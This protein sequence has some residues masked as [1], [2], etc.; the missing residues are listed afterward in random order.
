MQILLINPPEERSLQYHVPPLGLLW[1]SS[2]LEADGFETSVIDGDHMGYDFKKLLVRV[3]EEEAQIVGI[4]A[5]SHSR[6][7][8]MQTARLIKHEL[9]ATTIVVGGPHFSLTAEDTLRHVSEIDVVVRGEGEYTMLDLVH[10]LQRKLDM[11]KVLGISFR[12]QGNIVHNPPR[13]FIKDLDSLPFPNRKKLPL[14]EYDMKLPVLG[15]PAITMMATRGCPMRCAFCASPAI[16]GRSYRVRSAGNVCD[17]IEYILGEYKREGINFYDDTVNTSK[18]RI[19]ELCGEIK[20]RKLDFT[21]NALIRVD[22]ADRETLA[23]M[24]EAGCRYVAF[25][26][27]SGSPKVLKAINKDI[28]VE[29]VKRCVSNCNELGIRTKAFFLFS[30]PEE[31]EEDLTMTVKLMDELRPHLDVI[32]DIVPTIYPGTALEARAKEI[33]LLPADFS[34]S[35]PYHSEESALVGWKPP[36]VPV[37]REKLSL[38]TLARLRARN[39][40]HRLYAA[41]GFNLPRLLGQGIASLIHTK[42]LNE[43]KLNAQIALNMLRLAFGNTARRVAIRE[44]KTHSDSGPNFLG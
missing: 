41:K 36:N 24:K 32:A 22:K 38:N 13:P 1:L 19:F 17:E 23:E 35:A 3:R 28:T 26:V 43:L 6:H 27:E 40:A 8:A 34:W 5:T 42:D 15:I 12:Q 30:L 25:G 9:P 20:R 11:G 7:Q 2:V 4:T 18:R 14:L 37:Y 21:W 10:T 44:N 31:T 33:G 29:Q 39:E 16:W